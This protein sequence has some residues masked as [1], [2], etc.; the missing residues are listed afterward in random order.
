MKFVFNFLL[1]VGCLLLSLNGEKIETTINAE[2]KELKTNSVIGVLGAMPEEIQLIQQKAKNVVTHKLN[3]FITIF[4]GEIEGKKIV[5]GNSGVGKTFASS[6]VT[7]M[8]NQFQ[9]TS[10]IF[11]GL[12]G[13]MSE[14]IGLGDIIIAKDVIDYEMDCRNFKLPWDE[15]YQHK[16][17]EIP[18]LQLRTFPCDKKLIDIAMKTKIEVSKKL[19]RIASGSE[20]VI[21]SRKKEI[22]DKIWKELEFPDCLE[23]EGSA[24]AQICHV[25]Q[26]PFLLIRT[27]SDTFKGDANLEFGKFLKVAAQH[28]N[29]MAIDII[30]NL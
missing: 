17:G 19:G 26:I 24:V 27:I 8:I 14:S 4:E 5:F 20:F 1:I 22:Y 25:Y 10:L 6:V 11:T 9:I 15:T 12:A 29:E 28:N 2:S 7:T 13:G 23:M 30:K 16:L 21:Q 18:F 3:N